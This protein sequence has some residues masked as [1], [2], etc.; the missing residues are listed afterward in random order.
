MDATD[1]LWL[2]FLQALVRQGPMPT[3]FAL[4]ASVNAKVRA[5]GRWREPL[6][7]DMR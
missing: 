7:P 3:V 6:D 1:A 5:D 4:T 2:L